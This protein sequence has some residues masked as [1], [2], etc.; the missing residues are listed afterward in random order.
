MKVGPLDLPVNNVMQLATFVLLVVA[1]VY[2]ARKLPIPAQY[3]P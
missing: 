2:V 3:K 1:S